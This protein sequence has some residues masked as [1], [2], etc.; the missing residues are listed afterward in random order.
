V[1][2]KRVSL[3]LQVAIAAL[4]AVIAFEL[5]QPA[6][7]APSPSVASDYSTEVNNLHT[8]MQR[9]NSL[10]SQICEI[11]GQSNK[12]VPGPAC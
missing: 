10:L 8:D 2:Q 4:L 3:A 9:S 11:L 6:P 7:A 12:V 5:A 1:E